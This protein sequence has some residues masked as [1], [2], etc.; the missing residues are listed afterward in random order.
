[1]ELNEKNINVESLK[2]MLEGRHSSQNKI[3]VGYTNDKHEHH[4]LGERWTDDD[5]NEWEQKD[6]YAIKLGKEWQQELHEYLTTFKNCP[7]ETCTCTMPKRLDEKMKSIHGMCFDCVIDMEH[8]LK[9]QGKYNEYEKE[10]VKQNTMAWLE[11]AEKDKNYVIAE[12]TKSLEFVNSNGMVE[13]WSNNVDPEE[14]KNKIEE[15][16]ERFKQ[17]TLSNLEEYYARSS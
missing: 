1:M 9:I 12:L 8:K 10:K 6:G 11:Q 2:Q 17:E 4:D 5:G 14:L 7:K 13:K 15:E 16:F 3:Q